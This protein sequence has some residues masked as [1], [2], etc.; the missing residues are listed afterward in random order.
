VWQTVQVLHLDGQIQLARY[1]AIYSSFAS[2][3]MLLLWIYL[4]WSIF[5]VGAELAF[6]HQNEPMFTS[7][8]RTGK[9]DQAYRER[10]ALR[11]AAR[12]AHAFLRGL[13]PPTTAELAGELGV[14]PRTVAQVLESLVRAGLLARTGVG[15]DDGY[16]PA[17]A[18]EAITVRDL[19][20]A[21]R[22]E[23]GASQPPVRS[24]LDE[25]ADRLL[26]A[27]DEELARSRA[28]ATLVELARFA[29]APDGGPQDFQRP[30]AGTG[31]WPPAQ[32]G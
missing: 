20:L 24:P 10:V 7:M 32:K 13:R 11:L 18:P 16:L 8:A 26:E 28:N 3:P 31:S 2:I 21:L 30:G 12:S 1:N 29:L 19:L 22:H 17:R 5:L 25:Q 9:V 6:A 23:E 4:S 14:A 15:L 27:L